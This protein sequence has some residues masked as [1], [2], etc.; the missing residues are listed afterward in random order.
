MSDGG[1]S[2]GS[3][4]PG[5]A[6]GTRDPSK[7]GAVAVEEEHGDI[8]GPDMPFAPF[9][10]GGLDGLDGDGGSHGSGELDPSM[11]EE[12]R[13]ALDPQGGLTGP[14]LFTDPCYASRDYKIAQQQ[15][16]RDRVEGV[17]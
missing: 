10:G 7:D 3:S 1:S 8:P 15:I 4:A 11:N 5:S 2:A 13:D 6:P 17:Y 12:L 14:A 16:A 9:G